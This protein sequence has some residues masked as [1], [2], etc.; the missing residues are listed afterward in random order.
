MKKLTRLPNK[1]GK[2]NY[3]IAGDFILLRSSNRVNFEKIKEKIEKD[4]KKITIQIIT[5]ED[6]AIG[7][8]KSLG[9]CKENIKWNS[10]AYLFLGA[11]EQK[12]F[13]HPHVKDGSNINMSINTISEMINIRRH[14]DD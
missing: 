3:K 7:I 13:K 5:W 6:V 12:I 11:I 2:K 10:I 1:C 9:N 4:K 8:R 14:E